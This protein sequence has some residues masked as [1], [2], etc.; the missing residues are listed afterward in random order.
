VC[1]NG[2]LDGIATVTPSSGV[3]VAVAGANVTVTVEPTAA[4]GQRRLVVAVNEPAPARKARRT[5]QII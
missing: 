1:T 2:I 5:I 4:V 3:Q